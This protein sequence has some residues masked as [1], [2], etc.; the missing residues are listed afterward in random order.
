MAP[1]PAFKQYTLY[2]YFIPNLAASL[3]M[4]FWYRYTT[5]SSY[6]FVPDD[7]QDR[8][9]TVNRQS[10]EIRLTCEL[11]LP[12]IMM[13]IL[14]VSLAK[15]NPSVKYESRTISVYGII[16][17][18]SLAISTPV[19]IFFFFVATLIHLDFFS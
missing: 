7:A 18:I 19:I 12:I 16:G 11:L 9:L 10:G 17:I 1:S 2:V 6:T 15:I 13:S 3:L 8:T 4:L 14:N 5:N